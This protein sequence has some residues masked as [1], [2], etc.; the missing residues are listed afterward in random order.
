MVGPSTLSW[1]RRLACGV[2]GCPVIFA[3]AATTSH[4]RARAFANR[5][6]KSAVL[7]ACVW[8]QYFSCMLCSE[9]NN[10]AFAA[11]LLLPSSS[12]SPGTRP[13]RN[14]TFHLHPLFYMSLFVALSTAR[15]LLFDM[16]LSVAPST[17][18][19]SSSSG[20]ATSCTS[21][22]DDDFELACSNRAN[23][24]FT[25]IPSACAANSDKDVLECSR[26]LRQP[27]QHSPDRYCGT[28]IIHVLVVRPGVLRQRVAAAT[29]HGITTSAKPYSI[30]V[31]PSLLQGASI[32]YV[33]RIA[34]N[35]GPK[36]V[37]SL[38]SFASRLHDVVWFKLSSSLLCAERRSTYALT[39]PAQHSGPCSVT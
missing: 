16:P 5:G 38:V 25:G 21:D 13:H 35:P 30:T 12:S 22:D 4:A 19:N 37:T 31:Y 11:D 1:C 15:H 27:Q 10:A 3:D 26:T 18:R 17:A 24:G 39:T 8:V 33:A 7:C 2:R 29:R 23:V 34:C 6:T 9:S 14:R 28:V 36:T 32:I 20:Q